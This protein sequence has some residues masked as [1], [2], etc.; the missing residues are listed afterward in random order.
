MK[1]NNN[2]NK[3]SVHLEAIHLEIFHEKVFSYYQDTT[4]L[5]PNL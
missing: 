4:F 1:T 3:I 5:F 2:N